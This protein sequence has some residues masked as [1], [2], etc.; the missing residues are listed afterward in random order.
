MQ[1]VSHRRDQGAG[2]MFDMKSVCG[3]MFGAAGRANR[4]SGLFEPL[5]RRVVLSDYGPGAGMVE[6]RGQEFPAIQGAWIITFEEQL[7]NTAAEIRTRQLADAL[8]VTTTEVRSVGRGGWGW[9]ST[10]DE[11]SAERFDRVRGSVPFVKFLEPDALARTMAVP[12]DP[13]FG[14]QWHHEN[15][16]QIAPLTGPGT[17]GADISSTGAWDITIGD[18]D[19]IIGIIDSGVDY[20]HPDLA[21][22]IWVN[23]GEIP[24]NG[25]DDDGNGFVDDVIGWDFGQG[26]N[27]P[28]DA[29]GHGTGVAGAAAAVGNNGVG[30][31]GVAWNVSILPLKIA[32]QFGQIVLSAIVSAHDYA[33]MI[34]QSGFRL[35]ATNGSYGGYDQAFYTNAPTG[36]NAERDAIERYVNVGGIFVAA[37]GNDGF[38]NDDPNV[39]NFPSSYNI[40]GVIA[41][42][43]TDN[44]DGL[45]DFS[46]Y[47]AQSVDLGAPGQDIL[48]T[49]LGGGYEYQSGTSFAAPI[50]TGAVALIRSANPTASAIEVRAALFNSV[51]P[52]PS[53]Q[54]RTVSGGRLNVERALQI[55]GLD[56]PVV[57]SISPGPLNVAPVSEI[58]V[59]FSE[60]LDPA[61][62][63]TAG[64]ELLGSGG[65]GIFGNG[66]DLIRSI[67]SITL[68]EGDT[69]VTITPSPILSVDTY[70]LTLLETGFRDL[71]GNLLNGNMVIGSPEVYIFELVGVG[72]SFEPNDTLATSTQVAFGANS[73]AFFQGMLI[74]DGIFGALDVDIYRISMPRGGLITAKVDAQS[75]Q[76]PS[77][78]DSYLRLFNAAGEEIANNDQFNGNDSF[79]DFFVTTGG[80]Y[81]VGVSGFPNRNYDP[82][83]GGSGTS[84]AR[85]IYNL[86]LSIDLVQDDRRVFVANVPVPQTIPE[87]GVITS[88]INV[89]DSRLILDVNVTLTINHDFVSD[90][91]VSL[92]A[93]GGQTVMLFDG[94]GGSGDFQADP[95][96]P[97]ATTFDDEAATSITTT[98]PPWG[99]GTFRPEQALSTFDANTANGTWTLRI[100]DTT[101]LNEGVFYGWSIT[102]LLQNDIFGPFELN[103]TLTSSKTLTEING[104]GSATRNAAIG[105]GGFGTLDVDIFRFTASAGSTLN[106]TVTS[107]G[108]LNAGLRL[109][110][111]SG[112]EIKFS[113]PA[114]TNNASIQNFVFTAGGIYYIG[115]SETLN[116]EGP[117]A[118]DPFAAGSGVPAS[119]TGNYTLSVN[120]AQGVSDGAV[121]LVGDNLVLGFGPTAQFGSGTAGI[122][123]NDIEFLFP[124][125]GNGA[126]Q[127]Y[128]GAVASGFGFQNDGGGA[129]V[130]LP[131]SNIVQSD[132]ANLRLQ[133]RGVNRGLS[134]ERTISFS[135]AGSFIAFDVSLSN[136]T[137][138]VMTNVGW[139]EVFNPEMGVNLAP[140]TPNTF[141]DVRDGEPL[142]TARYTNNTFTNG[143]TIGIGAPAA[144]T[145]ALATVLPTNL[146]VRDPRQIIDFGLNDP[147]GAASNSLLAMAFDLGLLNAGETVTMRYFIFLG[148]TPTA[149]DQM[150]DALN[151]GTGTGHLTAERNAPANDADGI[152]D[153]PYRQYY[154]EGFANG[155]ASTFIPIMNPTNHAARIVIIA[156]YEVG[157]R[158]Q[159]LYD[160]LT[161][162]INNDGMADGGLAANTR[163]GIT[164]TTPD[165]YSQGTSTHVLSTVRE[166]GGALK[167]GLRK[168][169]PY[170]LEIRSDM[171]V[172]ATMS[173]FDFGVSTGEAFASLTSTSWSFPEISKG[174]GSNDFIIFQNT[175]NQTIKITTRL[176]PANGGAP[177]DLVLDVAA[178]RRA[179]W[180][181]NAEATSL[182][183]NGNY[184]VVITSQGP[185]VA[186]ISSYTPGTGGYGALATVG[187]GATTGATP[188]GQFGLNSDAEHI[189][190]FNGSNT[191]ATVTLTFSFDNGSAY[192][193]VVNV[194][195]LRR[196][197][198]DVA[199]LAGF[200]TGRAYGVSYESN[201]PVS[202][203]MPT[204]A[205]G[206]V[207]GASFANQ[208]RT[209]WAFSEGF[210]PAGNTS[211]VVEFLRVYNPA[212]EAVT[213]EIEMRF[214]DGQTEVFRRV[215]GDRRVTEID[216]HSLITGS[217][218][219]TQQFY[220]FTVKSA[221]PVIAYQGRSD[222]FFSG[223]FGTLGAALGLTG[224]V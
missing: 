215:V 224:I 203:S 122:R 142:A 165:L 136:F 223:S 75:L 156:R 38:N 155:R 78:L 197:T 88:F 15:I 101:A 166:P 105:D 37:A 172:I 130:D 167:L 99:G 41:V 18:R 181:L 43:A 125:G 116:V 126:T 157:D 221:T 53:L 111:P 209:L 132:A 141:N 162:D 185:I 220:G 11:V 192:R 103:D 158:D 191:A 194:P 22:N 94:R 25:I 119:S 60:A 210:R 139:M 219:Q 118:Y 67:S 134:I 160:S 9:F 199:K 202:A 26:T 107:N 7:G 150:Y 218:T 73:S 4:L 204:G 159:V 143:L 20:T 91:R 152:A 3:R 45:A 16:G 115:V 171:P 184:S 102:I 195:S 174:Q 138:N 140:P 190:F 35:A 211:Q 70:R 62:V 8:G 135:R 168:M 188:Q 175:T 96:L 193:H 19:V 44:N 131:M 21:A 178:K 145:R 55:V 83:V 17:V 176:L 30:V 163:G 127:S 80:F 104:T 124:S 196:A 169:T 29:V 66:N 177:I 149:V 93:P 34:L 87:V 48:T 110:D 217:R 63:N 6:W 81:Y 13:L 170:A 61:F 214:T 10:N 27:D 86:T 121:N 47:G 52:V 59:R 89:A 36:F 68:S 179:G 207:E 123:F 64:V 216:I 114:G 54:G 161:D 144:D 180:N 56:G 65:D 24:D 28:M 129:N 112:V 148:T 92:I 154:P 33:T 147:N 183:P 58:V 133:S 186:A 23:P 84:Q 71:N 189:T 222:A 106:A 1:A 90:L 117:N 2:A 82:E 77:N 100:E 57:R 31:S 137:S 153:L 113:N 109:F 32:N 97:V 98:P 69:V 12:N 182:I 46:N 14:E 76:T 95:N 187:L 85:G 198:V 208:A 128:F 74:G 213:I 206:E 39:T 205:F 5:E 201:V 212:T 72:T 164:L 200:P 40:P 49:A 173:H 108:S 50:V 42:A 79:V 120:V 51:D 146:I 151:A